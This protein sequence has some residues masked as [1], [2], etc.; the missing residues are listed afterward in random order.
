MHYINPTE[1][2]ALSDNLY[3]KPDMTILYFSK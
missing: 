1:Q 3:A 2:I